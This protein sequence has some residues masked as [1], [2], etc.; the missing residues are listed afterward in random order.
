MAN[1]VKSAGEYSFTLKYFIEIV[2][3]Y[4][5]DLCRVGSDAVMVGFNN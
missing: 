2:Q 1:R 5:A 3:I 4:A